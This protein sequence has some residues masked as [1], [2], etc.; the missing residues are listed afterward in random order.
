MFDANLKAYVLEV[1]KSPNLTPSADRYKPNTLS[2]EHVVYNTLK[3]VG[4]STY[5]ELRP[6]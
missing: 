6:R 3:L 1:N 4:L 5:T 2:Y